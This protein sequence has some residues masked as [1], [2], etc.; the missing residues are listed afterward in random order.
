[1]TRILIAGGG[2][3]G[4][5]AAVRAAKRGADV[6]LAEKAA[7]GVYIHG[8]AGDAAADHLGSR[9][10]TARDI[11]EFLPEILKSRG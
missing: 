11:N 1:M 10:M 7:L 5:A 8:L 6:T 3:A 4:A 2:W 9:G